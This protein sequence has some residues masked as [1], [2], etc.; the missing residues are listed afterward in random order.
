MFEFC[1]PPIDDQ[2]T[3]FYFSDSLFPLIT[4]IQLTPLDDTTARETKEAGLHIGKQLHEVST[5][6]SVAIFPGIAR[7][8]G[9]HIDID[10]SFSFKDDIQFSFLISGSGG[11]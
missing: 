11:H 2:F 9:D 1:I 10:K 7:E 3:V 4:C 5:H 6:S 8:H